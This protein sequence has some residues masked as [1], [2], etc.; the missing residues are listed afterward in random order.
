MFKVGGSYGGIG[1]V[2]HINTSNYY[3]QL[4][5]VG[6]N[7]GGFRGDTGGAPVHRDGAESKKID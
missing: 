6:G 4:F 5:Y 7:I 2:E 1:P 3:I